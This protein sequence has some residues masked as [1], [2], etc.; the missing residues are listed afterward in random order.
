MISSSFS[1]KTLLLA[2]AFTLPGMAFA[3]D[4]AMTKDGMLVDHNGMTLY[5]FAKDAGGKSMCNDKCATNW[6]PLA[7][8]STAK[9]MGKW[10]AIKR[11][12]GH[13]QW[14]YDGKPLYTFVM[15]KKAGDATG[16]GKMDGAWK[17]AKP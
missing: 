16:D 13:M 4:P 10:T 2:A 3:A 11:D 17:V 12:D 14:A 9:D 15:D 6:P 7:A 5:T 8:E 1:L